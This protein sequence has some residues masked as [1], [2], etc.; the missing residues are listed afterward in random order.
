MD[1]EISLGLR[2]NWKQF[3][4]LVIVNSFVG[5][6]VG[7]ERSILPELAEVRFG[8]EA[9]TAIFSFIVIFGVSK[10]VTNYFMGAFADRYGRKRLLVAGWLIALPI[11]FILIHAPS[12]SWI[13]VAMVTLW[14]VIF[15][16]L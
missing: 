7:L 1:R 15:I 2:K 16:I 6:M 9:R 4:L 8:L 13:V 10:A 11:P 5:G 3:A 14:C 12:W